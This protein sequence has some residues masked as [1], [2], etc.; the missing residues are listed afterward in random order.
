[1]V[2]FRFDSNSYFFWKCDEKIFSFFSRKKKL[3]IHFF[4]RADF[5]VNIF[6][7]KFQEKDKVLVYRRFSVSI[8]IIF[9]FH[10]P[11]FKKKGKKWCCYLFHDDT[12]HHH[13]EIYTCIFLIVVRLFSW[14]Q[15]YEIKIIIFFL[16]LTTNIFILKTEHLWI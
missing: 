7:R 4:S 14:I 9:P 16:F 3:K 8:S 2:N 1:M 11:R 10:S 13:V 12:S 5:V 6:S 15:I